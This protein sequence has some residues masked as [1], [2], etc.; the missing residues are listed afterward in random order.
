[1]N[2]WHIAILTVLWMFGVQV[3]TAAQTPAMFDRIGV[4]EGLP[5]SY[6]EALVQDRYGYLWIGTRGGLVRHEGSRLRVLRHD[7]DQPGSLPGNNVLALLAASD[8]SLWAA[9]SDQG[10]V[11]LDG[12]T[13][14]QHFKPVSR[15]GVL[16][17]NYIWSLAEACDG[18]IWALYA[19]GGL[20]R[21]DPSSGRARHFG[22]GDHGLPAAGFGLQL[23][24]VRAD[25]LWRID[26][27]PPH[28]FERVLGAS[29]FDLDVLLALAFVDQHRA[30]LGGRDAIVELLLDPHDARARS[31]RRWPTGRPVSV[32]VPADEDGLWVGLPDDFWLLDPDLDTT[33]RFSE[34][35]G[36]AVG[37]LQVTDLLPGREGEIWIATSGGGVVRLPPG[38]RGLTA[39]RPSESRPGPLNVTAVSAEPDGRVWIGGDSGGNSG[40]V[41][42]LDPDRGERGPIEPIAVGRGDRTPEVIDLH[43]DAEGLW[44]LHRR[45]LVRRMHIDGRIVPVLE[46]DLDTEERFEF[47]APDQ[48]GGLWLGVEG[49]ELLRL[50]RD[51]RIIDRWHAD[52]DHDR[53]L[54]DP[55]PR[56]IVRAADGAWWFLGSRWLYRFDIDGRPVPVLGGGDAVLQAMAFADDRLWLASDSLLQRLR[57]DG[58]QLHPE[59][60]LTAR[61]GLPHGTI[62]ALVP[63]AGRVWVLTSAGLA[64]FD[65]EQERFRQFSVAEGLRL[66]EF[67]PGAVTTLADGRILAGSTAGLLQVEPDRIEIAR[68]PPPVW[69]TGVRSGDREWQLR[70]GGPRRLDLDWREN[71]V[72]LSYVALSYLNPEGNRYRVRLHGWDRDWL[73]LTGETERDYGRLPG[74]RYRFEVQAAG[75]DGVWNLHGDALELMIAAP[76]WRTGWAMALYVGVAVAL[77]ALRWRTLLLRRRRLELLR[78]ARERQ[79]I[80]DAASAA[81]SEFLAV[82]SHE[83]RTPLHGLLGMMSLLEQRLDRPSGREMLETMRRSGSQLKRI[84]DDALELSSIEAGKVELQPVAVPLPALLEQAVDLRAGE[85]WACGLGLRLRIASDLPLIAVVDPDRLAQLLGNLLGNA[86][87]FTA[88]GAVELEARLDST[89][90]L[91]LAVTDTGPGIDPDRAETLFVPYSRLEADRP[92]RVEGTGLGLAI[93]KRLAAAMGGSIDLASRPGCGSR[94]TLRL[95]LSGMTPVAPQRSELLEGVRV[96]A[97]LPAAEMR[98]LRRLARRWRIELRR[99]GRDDVPGSAEVL[100]TA[101]G[102]VAAELLAVWIDA[103]AAGLWLAAEDAPPGGMT[104]L[105]PPLTEARLLGALFELRLAALDPSRLSA[106]RSA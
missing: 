30:Y 101:P 84:V 104:R 105:R 12:T 78:R 103:G 74:G 25:S 36:G 49:G 45:F 61:H 66:A 37:P 94:F 80:A 93:C 64:R 85:A 33:L 4:A 13:V 11:R 67:N 98:V 72:R 52:A 17:G 20:V 75:V 29:E 27:Q 70:P 43:A 56:S 83:I 54:E 88:R 47:I 44:V 82:M 39:F 19:R 7:P 3:P 77:L 41:Q 73:A 46:R 40:G 48:A 91:V 99:I 1:L 58:D 57:L 60:R 23:W 26:L 59:L 102:M 10:L 16:E 22:P 34:D 9:I 5:D 62:Q 95:P 18:A 97:A 63:Q 2:L 100:L 24:M 55:A 31:G 32:L 87:K 90:R 76:P 68:R 28:A 92:E 96:A 15:G 69:L 65:P 35:A 53:R 71:S 79:Q 86:I 8:G 106:D 14:A 42:W 51:G 50:D 89:G 81:K 38:W 21:I 6:V